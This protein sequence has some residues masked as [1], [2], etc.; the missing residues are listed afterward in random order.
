MF[1]LYFQEQEPGKIKECWYSSI[2]TPEL[3]YSEQEFAKTLLFSIQWCILQG[4]CQG[5]WQLLQA[6]ALPSV[7]FHP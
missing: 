5:Y 3:S 2:A 6:L 4:V 1:S 7:F